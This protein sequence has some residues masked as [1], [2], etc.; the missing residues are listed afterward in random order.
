MYLNPFCKD[1]E[2][3]WSEVASYR[4]YSWKKVDGGNKITLQY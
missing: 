2:L 3:C 4:F 1:N